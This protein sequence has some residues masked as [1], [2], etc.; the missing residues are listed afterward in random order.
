MPKPCLNHGENH[1]ESFYGVNDL[2]NSKDEL[3]RRAVSLERDAQRLRQEKKIEE[4]F[5]AYD[6]AA[7]C[8]D[9]AGESLKSSLCFAS[10]A[11]CWLIHAGWEPLRKA[12]GCYE[13]AAER[14]AKAGHYDTARMYF[15]E[16]ARLYEK[17]GDAGKFS[18]C[19][20]RSKIADGRFMWDRFVSGEEG[21]FSDPRGARIGCRERFLNFLRWG[22]N[23]LN[24]LVWG[25]G[26]YPFRALAT[27]FF[28]ILVCAW[29]YFISG[30]ISVGGTVR[31]VS[32]AEGAYM[33]AVIFS[34]VGFGDYVP[35]GWVR[36][37]AIL[38][39]LGGVV[40]VPLFLVALTRRYLRTYH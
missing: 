13:S 12:A 31:G 16:A 11:T 39:G 21:K 18:E 25:Y 9:K 36:C 28:L 34:T 23:G 1:W 22:V 3:V 38:E 14:A 6:E 27:A 17:E 24:R 35:I 29:A 8:Y 33:S 20:Y 2:V 5:T 19:F 32:L 30:Q 40:L 7:D 10:A 4:A 15:G 37:F 26:E